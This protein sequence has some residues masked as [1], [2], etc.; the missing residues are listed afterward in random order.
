MAPP[1]PPWP[2]VQRGTPTVSMKCSLTIMTV[3][4]LRTSLH[5]VWKVFRVELATA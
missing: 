1:L 4:A 5:V 2:M 3:S